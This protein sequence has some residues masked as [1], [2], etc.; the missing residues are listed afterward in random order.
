MISP[1]FKRVEQHTSPTTSSLTH[2]QCHDDGR[3]AT[4]PTFSQAATTSLL[5]CGSSSSCSILSSTKNYQQ[6]DI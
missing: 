2:Q 6:A 5:F 1:Q 4:A 3:N